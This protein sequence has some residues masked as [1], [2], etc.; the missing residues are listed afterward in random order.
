MTREA[1]RRVR[2]LI[3]MVRAAVVERDVLGLG[4]AEVGSPGARVQGLVHWFRQ[5]AEPLLTGVTKGKPVPTTWYWK[6]IQRAVDKGHRDALAK[7]RRIGDGSAVIDAPV[8][9]SFG[10][11]SKERTQKVAN[12][13]YTHMKDVSEEMSDRLA[14][15]LADGVNRGSAPREIA[16]EIADELGIGLSRA[17]V[18]AQTEIIGAHA[19]GALDE[20]ES[21]EVE[22]VE[23]ES[24]FVTA[25]DDVVCP[26][27]EELEGNVYSISEARGII[28]VHP[29]CRCAWIPVA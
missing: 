18:I 9:G 22:G 24:E 13:V 19:D 23:V 14:K 6:H 16:G 17:K 20:F 28:P 29:N 15:V 11:A 4:R 27:C 3:A 1:Q 7:I 2:Q 10:P 12:K 8:R 21:G 5:R 26:E 25:G